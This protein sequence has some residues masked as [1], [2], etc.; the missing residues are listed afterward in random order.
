MGASYVEE[1]GEQ[2]LQDKVSM[3][4]LEKIFSRPNVVSAALHKPGS[5]I[6][7]SDGKRYI[8]RTDGS[9]AEVVSTLRE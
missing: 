9:W 7:Q 6:T 3:D 2:K 4:K 5:E 8:V 1:G